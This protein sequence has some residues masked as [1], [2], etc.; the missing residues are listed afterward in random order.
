MP[1]VSPVRLTPSSGGGDQPGRPRRER[2]SLP[3]LR[4]HPCP[5][6]SGRPCPWIRKLKLMW[7]QLAGAWQRRAKGA[8]KA[9]ATCGCTAFRFPPGPLARRQASPRPARC[10]LGAGKARARLPPM[11][12][13]I[14]GPLRVGGRG[15]AIELKAAKQR[16][17]LA[18]LLLA[19]RDDGVS[20]TRLIDVLWG[21]AAARRPRPRRSRSSL[22]AAPRARRGHDRH[23]PVR[24]RDPARPRRSTS[25]ASRRWSR[26]AA[27]P[28]PT[29]RPS[30]C[31]R[32]SRSSAARRWPTRRSRARHRGRPAR[33][34]AADAL[35]RRIDARPGRSAATAR[36][37]PSWRRSPPSTLPRALP[38]AA[39]ARALPLGAPG[40]RA[41]GLPAR[42]H[43]CWSRS[44]ASSP[45][46][47][48]SSWRRR[49]SPQDPALDAARGAARPRAG[50]ARRSRSAATRCSAATRTWRPPRAAARPRRRLLTLTGPG[51]IGKTRFALELAHRLGA[52]VRRRRAVRRARRPRDPAQVRAELEPRARRSDGRRCCRV[53]NFEQLLDAAPELSR[54]AGRLAAARSWSSRAARRCGSRPSTSWRS[55]RSRR[56]RRRA[57][58]PPRP[59]RRPAPAA[60]RRR[61]RIEQICAR[62]DGLPLAIEL[63]AARIKVLTPAAILER[64]ARRLD[65][66]SSGP[67]D[68]P[69]RQQTLR[70]AIGW[71]YDLLD[72]PASAVR[73]ARRVRR[74]LHAPGRRGGLRPAT[75][76]TASPALADHSLLTRDGRRFGMLE[77][78]REYALEQLEDADA[79]RDRHARAFARALEGAEAGMRSAELPHWLA[80]LD[81]EHD[82]LR[83]ALRHATAAGD[84][85]TAL[86]L[87]WSAAQYWVTRGNVAEG[88]ELAEAALAAGGRPAGAAACTSR[89]APA[90]W[91]PSRATSPP[92][93][94]TSRRPGPRPRDRRT[95]TRI[96]RTVTQPGDARDVR[97]ATTRRRSPATRRRPRSR[98]SSATSAA[99]PGA[100]EPRHRARGRRAP[101]ARDRGARGKPRAGPAGRPI[102]ATWCRSSARSRACCSTTIRRARWRPAREPRARARVRRPQWDRRTAG[103]GVGRGGRP[104]RRGDGR[105]AVG[106]GRR[107]ARRERGDP[108]TRRGGLGLRRLKLRCA[109][110]WGQTSFDSGV[111]EGAALS[112]DEAVDRALA[113]G[114]D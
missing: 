62:L 25:P 90:C 52:R 96:A 63:A 94:R 101:R 102:P 23:A 20:M 75:R 45:A 51:G 73:P 53:D 39:D 34:A 35:E 95:A 19:Y 49:S 47:T 86:S 83:A 103:D 11:E 105:A 82:N 7:G 56:A 40:R 100:A 48:S 6:R 41:R 110:R 50:G 93:G 77:T 79:V 14:L 106:G 57:V 92:P 66:L 55:A 74:R 36:S 71:S 16:A 44:S 111:V 59:R 46:A 9:G 12:F 72:A 88:R 99:Q 28:R 104:R 70:A 24:L 13:A 5:F 4:G 33:G 3:L 38:R 60:R 109:R 58:H 80:R 78:V 65:L 87:I 1:C 84:V 37:R 29:R 31:A 18:V 114:R 42:P 8:V 2:V 112:F 68:A 98:A 97:A 32:R 26:R 107:A 27:T 22:P 91:R 43:A 89:T 69:V 54:A 15:G 17:L 76:S 30:C 21:D 61:A 64:L 67:R 108:P 10:R 85:E 81:A 113:I